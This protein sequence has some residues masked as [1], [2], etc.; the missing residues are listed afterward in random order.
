MSDLPVKVGLN[1]VWVKPENLVEF[2]V[3]A[4]ALG[5]TSRRGPASTSVFR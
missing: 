3:A 4:E 2:G 5:G 1:I